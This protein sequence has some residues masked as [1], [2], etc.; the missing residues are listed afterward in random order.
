LSLVEVVKNAMFEYIKTKNH[1][2]DHQGLDL[3]LRMV[4]HDEPSP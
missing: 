3:R 2:G 4:V 1:D